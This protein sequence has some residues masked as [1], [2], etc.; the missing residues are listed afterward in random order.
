MPRRKPEDPYRA[1]R[2]AALCL[3]VNGH[4][5]EGAALELHIIALQER[6]AKIGDKPVCPHCREPLVRCKYNGYYDSFEYWDCG[7]FEGDIPI[8]NNVRGSYG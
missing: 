5:D 1:L 7:C 3:Y 8:T 2:E 4:V 6:D